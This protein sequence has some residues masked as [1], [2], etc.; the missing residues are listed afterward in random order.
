MTLSSKVTGGVSKFFIAPVIRNLPPSRH[1][2]LASRT[3]AAVLAAVVALAT[4]E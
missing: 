3:Q 4:F 2:V 1:A